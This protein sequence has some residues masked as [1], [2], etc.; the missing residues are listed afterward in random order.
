MLQ[1]S[2]FPSSLKGSNSKPLILQLI[3]IPNCIIQVGAMGTPLLEITSTS[4]TG[5]ANLKTVSYKGCGS[6]CHLLRD[7]SIFFYMTHLKSEG[8]SEWN[9]VKVMGYFLKKWRSEIQFIAVTTTNR[10]CWLDKIRLASWVLLLRF[11][12]QF[13]FDLLKILKSKPF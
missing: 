1:K 9:L 13:I 6:L 8:F 11:L 10:F 7:V 12:T 5:D 2:W 3:L 4:L